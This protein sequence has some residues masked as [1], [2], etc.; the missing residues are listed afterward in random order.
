[1]VFREQIITQK[2]EGTP[3]EKLRG[4]GYFSPKKGSP[5]ASLSGTYRLAVSPLHEHR[6][7]HV[8]VRI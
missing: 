7:N 6:Y 2:S 4:L 5:S 1:M 8:D 3:F